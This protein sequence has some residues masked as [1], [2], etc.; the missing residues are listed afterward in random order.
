MSKEKT[1][2]ML[3]DLGFTPKTI[4]DCGAAWG[5]W[6]GMIRGYFPESFIIGVDANRWSEGKIINTNV[7]YFDALS[8]E[9]GKEMIFYKN[10]SSLDSN[11]FCTGD[12][13]FRENTIH[14]N[15]SNIVKELVKTKTL[16]SILKEQNCEKVDLLKID[17]QGSELII[18]KGLG[19]F[20]KDIEFIELE[21]S[22]VEF[23]VG[24]PSFVEILN[25][26]KEYFDIFEI[27]STL[28]VNGFLYQMDVIFKNKNSKIKP[29]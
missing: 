22:I 23:N 3:S 5:E 13:L 9:D 19:D 16:K 15:D 20:I 17:T 27:P 7:T 29:I 8:D 18:M 6:S 4:V 24:G 26:L 21:C 2:K 1:Y 10:K 25:F 14:Y 28:R 11:T 12:S